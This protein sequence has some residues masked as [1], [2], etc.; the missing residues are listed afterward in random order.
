MNDGPATP[1][2]GV[3]LCACLNA[4]TLAAVAGPNWPSTDVG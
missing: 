4:A 2:A 3:M 1:L